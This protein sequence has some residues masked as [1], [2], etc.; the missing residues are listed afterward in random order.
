MWIVRLIASALVAAAITPALAHADSWM[1]GEAPAAVA[2]S[3]AQDG[4]FR[5]GVMP[6]IGAYR[7]NGWLAMGLRLRAGVLRNGPAPGNNL[8]DPQLGGLGT[9]TAAL[10]VH[11]RSLW[12][13]LAG[14][15]GITGKDL[16]P[17]VEAGI[18]WSFAAGD[19]GIGPGVRYVGVISR[20]PMSTYGSASLVVVGLDV[21]WGVRRDPH[22]HTL[23]PPA[24]TARIAPLPEPT[25]A[26]RDEDMVTDLDTSC[27][28]AP[29]GCPSE[30][31]SEHL[32]MRNDRI[33][34]DE[35]VLFDLGRSRVRSAGREMIAEIAKA[36]RAHPEWKRITIEG[37]TDVRGSDEFNQMLSEHRAQHS[38]EVLLRHGFD[39]AT[40]D[41]V[42]YGRSRPRDP[43]EDEPAHHRNR[44]VEFVIE[45]EV[46]P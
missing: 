16:V 17:T 44:R 3:D 31:I 40:V 41:A 30:V 22:R 24:P 33:V 23:R 7:D 39:P 5:P 12:L 6:A 20:D 43:G 21:Q 11:R 9:L 15:G 29:D 32:V 45:R 18:G 25:P 26:E 10:R 35:R 8:T 13:E 28:Q 42:G 34:L 1:V 27:A 4:I 36:W 19:F 37:H 46:A 2:V 38:R 14:G